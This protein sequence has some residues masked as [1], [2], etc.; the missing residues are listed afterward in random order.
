MPT[1]VYHEAIPGHHFQVAI[2]RELELPLYRNVV[3][4][5]AYIEGWAMYA[6]RLGWELGLY[7]DPYTN[8]GRLE[9][10]LLRAVRLVTD[11][12]IHAK[13]WTREEAIAYMDEAMGAPPGSSS[14][15]V[16]RFIVWPAQATSYKVG[17]LKMVELRQ[18]A[19]DRLGD[20]FDLKEFHTVVLGNGGM[21]LE[22]LEQ[23]IQDYIFA[24][25]QPPTD[26]DSRARPTAS[27]ADPFAS[28]SQERLFAFLEDLTGIQA[29]SGWRNSASQGEVEAL[30]YVSQQLSGFPYLHDVG[31]ELER[32]GFHVFLGT[33]LWETGLYLHLDGQEMEVPADGLRGPRDNVETALRFDSDGKLNDRDR[34]PLMVDGPVVLVRSAAQ[35]QA[36]APS[37]VKGKV[38]FLDY[39][40]VNLVVAG[41]KKAMGLAQSLLDKD[42]AGLVV[43]TQ[44]STEQGSS[45]G[46]GIGDVSIFNHARAKTPIPI[47][48][49]RMEDMAPAGISSWDDLRRV[50][51]ARLTWDADVFSPADSGNLVARVPGLDPSRAII[52]GAHIDSPNSPGALD[53]GSGS[54]VLLEV[55][56]VLD[57]AHIQPPVDLYLAW[58]GSEELGLYGAAHFAATHQEL[59]DRTLAMLE[60]DC[61]SRPLDGIEADL[62]LISWS[63]SRLGDERLPWPDYL[64]EA[65]ARHEIRVV[66]QDS[67]FLYAEDLAF[68]GFGV[69]H[70]NLI[71]TNDPVMEKTGSWHY[72]AHVHD[73][74]ETVELT[75]EV[76]DV[77]EHMAQVTLAA[78][79]DA[80]EEQLMLRVAP[81]PDRRA[82]FVASHTESVHMMPAVFIELGMA[83]AW[84]GFDVDL[85]PY[86]EPVT[87]ADLQ[88]ADLVVALPVV[89]YPS[90]EGDAGVYDEAWS[91]E[92]VAALEAYVA[93]GGLLTLTNSAHRLKYYNV[94]LDP[95][96]DWAD[97]NE[98]AERFGVAY[99]E[100]T[101][102]AAVARIQGE[103]PLVVGV[104]DLHLIVKNGVPF[105][106][107]GG[108]TLAQAEGQ[109]VLALVDYGE[110]GGQVLV[111]AD[112]GILGSRGEPHNLPFWRNLAR[113][114]RSR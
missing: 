48:Y 63:Y 19:M 7:D 47:L 2:A 101:L 17:M 110:A 66:P 65:A 74:Y 35:S 39:A 5:N 45:H 106:L 96:E 10:E 67:Q 29:Y 26:D 109:P 22:I 36:L 43:V 68:K 9:F 73:P 53:D 104:P 11:T 25:L 89:D 88:D 20:Q 59:L 44:F 50:E 18:R 87:A 23:V 58:F 114:A 64:V 6:E 31:L 94:P 28:I 38:V 71:Y 16:D 95:N 3:D 91:P 42:P 51:A 54:A 32:Q 97:A 112:L 1:V 52:L 4:F 14:G 107:D 100:G 40:S 92:E 102:P 84:E 78:A 60:V 34:N 61:L 93:G 37:D 70:A 105:T 111:L 24:K 75:R 81:R 90:P 33:D 69:P 13:R 99:Q 85:I 12:G 98:L 57:A 41:D 56:R 46:F 86:G 27:T 77:L 79:L 80:G 83:L 82:L 103:H 55:A 49:A 76:G 62:T 8:L 113:Y 21:P 72:A 15:E 30:D 108:Q